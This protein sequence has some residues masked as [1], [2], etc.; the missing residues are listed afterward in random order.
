MDTLMIG[1]ALFL[2]YGW[3]DVF[4]KDLMQEDRVIRIAAPALLALS[5]ITQNKD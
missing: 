2:D 1:I 4:P 5:M 3:S